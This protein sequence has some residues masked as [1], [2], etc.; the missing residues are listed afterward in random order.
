MNKRLGILLGHIGAWRKGAQGDAGVGLSAVE[1]EV[2]GLRSPT[3]EQRRKLE[4]PRQTVNRSIEDGGSFTE[5]EVEASLAASLDARSRNG[6]LPFRESEGS[7][8]TGS[9][10]GSGS[11][12]A[13]K[14]GGMGET[15]DATFSC[16]EA[17]HPGWQGHL[18]LSNAT[19]RVLH[20]EH[21]STGTY[22]HAGP[23]LTVNWD[24]YPSERFVLRGD[25]YIHESL[26]APD[27]TT[28]PLATIY[29]SPF[30][31]KSFSIAVPNSDVAV[32]LRSGTT[33]IPIFHQVFI[34]RD[35]ESQY[36]PTAA[37][38][39]VDLGANTGLSAVYFGIKYANA[40]IVC[41]EPDIDNYKTLVANLKG[42]GGRATPLFGAAWSEDGT[43]YARRKSSD[44]ADL[45]A[46]G[47]QVSKNGDAF[48][49]EVP[50]FTLPTLLNLLDGDI[51][52]LKVDIEGAELEIFE[53][54]AREW[55][56]R[57]KLITVE[58][59]D[60]FRPG[61]DAAVRTAVARSGFVELP[62]VGENLFFRRP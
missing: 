54:N 56:D 58:T 29:G 30:R 53:S 47:V 1:R 15:I 8:S 51:D 7:A 3:S 24:S 50:A 52:I 60:R 43:I 14:G 16:F 2:R 20:Q 13:A 46:W 25:A 10:P 61:S 32:T 21:K 48:D 55:L 41:V 11:I 57:V 42:L 36:L 44:G 34:S 12:R 59:H 18:L 9:T 35:Y 39:I 19:D 62:R 40:R 23:V 31:L 17:V 5:E 6:S 38:N 4:A 22:S 27:L 33:D 26:D 28:A 37:K 49:A 45:G